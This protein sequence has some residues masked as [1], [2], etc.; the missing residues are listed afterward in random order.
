MPG[1]RRLAVYLLLMI[2][3]GYMMG[4]TFAARRME[5]YLRLGALAGSLLLLYGLHR[6]ARWCVPGYRRFLD[7][8][9]ET[10][11]RLARIG[12]AVLLG[13]WL[14]IPTMVLVPIGVGLMPRAFLAFGLA[15]LVLFVLQVRRGARYPAWLRLDLPLLMLLLVYATLIVMVFTLLGSSDRTCADVVSS[16]FLRPIVTRA[17]VEATPLVEDCFPY[18]VKSD[19]AHDRLFFTLKQNRSGFIRKIGPQRRANDAICVTSL[20]SPSFGNATLIPIRGDSTCRYPQR[21]TVNPARQEIYVVVLDLSGAHT[22]DVVSYADGFRVK[23]R[24]PVDYEPI[25]VYVDEARG[26]LIVLGYEGMVGVF[27]IETYERR[28]FRRYDD[29]GFI[30]MLDTL[31]PTPDGSA[32][33]A[34]VVSPNFLLIDARDFTIRLKRRVGVPTIG[35]DY[36]AEHNRVYAAG[37][38]TQEILVL[39]GETLEPIDRIHTGTTVRE[40]YIDRKRG[41][42]I[43]A[44]YADGHLDLY[45]LATHE[46]RARLFIGTLARGIHLER[47]SGRL[48]VTSSCG[49]FEVDVDAL[50]AGGGEG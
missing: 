11:R 12:V 17:D 47:E 10:V 2:P 36:D 48:F 6:L 13:L 29:L 26:E 38:L 46:R 42:V 1:F 37:T 8:R 24:L 14:L 33:F 49:L 19:P 40:L 30:G 7:R 39:D 22:I 27:D 35:L 5:N 3:V 16:P 23:H 21:I 4:I 32:F 20:S 41:L 44:G 9:R 28:L 45:D 50:L 18:D 15:L 34:S 25:R 31:V 43:T